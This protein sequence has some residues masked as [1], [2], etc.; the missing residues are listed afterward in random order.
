MR[1][2]I[3]LIDRRYHDHVL[4]LFLRGS[5]IDWPQNQKGVGEEK[6]G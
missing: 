6:R 1:C 2:I 4:L 3:H 5:D